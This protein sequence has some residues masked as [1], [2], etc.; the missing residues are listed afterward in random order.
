MNI[1]AM[2]LNKIKQLG[3]KALMR[4]LGPAGMV[5]FIQQYETGEGD[6]SEERY[7]KLGKTDVKALAGKIISQR[8]KNK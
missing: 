5:R 2:T 4:E 1:D 6:Y 7:K 8:K 3:I